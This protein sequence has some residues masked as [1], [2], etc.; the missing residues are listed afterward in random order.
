[1]CVSALRDEPEMPTDDD[2]SDVAA[3]S[4]RREVCERFLSFEEGVFAQVI[5]LS[6][7]NFGPNSCPIVG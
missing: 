1:M 7:V 2:S 5:G 3:A 6:N 4:V